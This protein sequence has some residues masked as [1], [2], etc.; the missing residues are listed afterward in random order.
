M[1][2]L[3]GEWKILHHYN[4]LCYF[5]HLFCIDFGAHLPGNVNGILRAFVVAFSLG[6]MVLHISFL[7]I[8]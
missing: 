1:L 2:M 6:R 7:E 3:D 4:K 8:A 5:M